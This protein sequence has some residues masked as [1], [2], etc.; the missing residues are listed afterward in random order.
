MMVLP[1]YGGDNPI[2]SSQKT[3]LFP[4][5]LTQQ[6]MAKQSEA[7]PSQHAL[8]YFIMLA[9]CYS[10]QAREGQFRIDI[11]HLDN[12]ITTYH[13]WQESCLVND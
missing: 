3:Q 9:I 7:V 10:K 11:C 2:S 12:I 6:H 4:L 8:H 1:Y 5:N 13:Y